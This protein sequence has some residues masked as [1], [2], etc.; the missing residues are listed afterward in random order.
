MRSVWSAY[1]PS[2]RAHALSL[3]ITLIT[4][5]LGIALDVL[6]PYFIRQLVDVFSAGSPAGTALTARQIFLRLVILFIATNVV[7]R[8]FGYATAVFEA[9]V[10]RD[11]C[12]RSFDVLQRQSL[13]FFRNNFTGSLVKSVTRFVNAF[14]GL[15][16]AVFFQIGRDLVLTLIIFVIFLVHS[17]MMAL[18]FGVWIMVFISMSILLA[19]W[20]YP[21][22][23]AEAESDSA[24]GGA[25]ADSLGNHATVK[26]YA[27]EASEGTRFANVA[28][29]NYACRL[30]AWLMATHFGGIQSVFMAA[31]QLGLVWFLIVGWEQGT[32]SV[33]DFVF[34]QTYAGWL[35]TNL[36]N[37]S[38]TLRRAFQ[39]VADASEV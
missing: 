6:Y 3:W 21:Y 14:E 35:C 33:G 4:L 13:S 31:F 32:F 10:M 19:R 16:D 37:F 23:V 26:S 24:V 25:L 36:W 34:F 11:L 8:V 5:V 7:W 22:D 15:A 27:M 29:R 39:Q 1:V 12:E 28:H 18:L 9:R 20:K 38:N 17:P 30:R 2:I